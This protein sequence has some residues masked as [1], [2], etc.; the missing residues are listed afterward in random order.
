[1]FYLFIILFSVGWILL[2]IIRNYIHTNNI[3]SNKYLNHGTLNVSVPAHK[4][5]NIKSSPLNLR[6]FHFCTSVNQRTFSTLNSFKNNITPTPTSTPIVYEDAFLIREEIYKENKEKSGIYMLTNKLTDD[7]YVGQSIDLSKRLKKYFT[8]SYISDRDELIIHRALKKYG[9]SNFSVTIL[10]YCDISDLNAREQYY[11]D[12]L[13]P[14]YNIL[15]VAGSSRGRKL[16]EET[17]AKISKALKGNYVGEK[18]YWYGRTMGEETKN[19]MSLNRTGE[20]NP[21]YGKHHSEETKELMRQ[22]ALGRK[23]SE[24]TKLLM[25]TK[26]GNPVCVY[27]KC[28]GEDF[29]LIGNFVSARRAGKFLGMSGSTVIRY[30]KSGEIFKDRYKFSSLKNKE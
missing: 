30:M 10:E 8:L 13:N 15:K 25:S 4:C 16:T 24:E 5:S 21:L 29:K 2:S 7:I 17:K 6:I 22:K 23:Y 26:R 18:A 28:S 3:I 11:F 14:Q 12:T 19:L 1:M 20:L 27:E 9:Y